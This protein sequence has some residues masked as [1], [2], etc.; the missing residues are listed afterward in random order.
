MAAVS[1]ATTDFSIYQ[2]LFSNWKK[3]KNQIDLFTFY[4]GDF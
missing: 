1:P 4:F 3:F 2:L